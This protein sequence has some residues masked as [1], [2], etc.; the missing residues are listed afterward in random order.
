VK[1]KIKPEAKQ[2]VE[3]TEGN[4]KGKVKDRRNYCHQNIIQTVRLVPSQPK[5]NYVDT[6]KGDAHALQFSGLEPHYV[7]R[8]VHLFIRYLI[9]M[10]VSPLFKL[11]AE[12]VYPVR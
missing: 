4:L 3:Q 7:L 1:E 8:K 5:R 12:I 10:P 11:T 9:C 6:K 2:D